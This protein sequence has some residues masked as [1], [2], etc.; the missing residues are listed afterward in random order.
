[1]DGWPNDPNHLAWCQYAEKQ[2]PGLWDLAKNYALLDHFHSSMLGPSFP[3]H[4]FVLAA[5]AGW[6]L[7]NPGNLFPWGCDAFPGT[8]VSVL[9]KG[10]CT[11]QNIFPCLSIP[12]A[13]DILAPGLT[14]KFYGSGISSIVW[15][16]FD[17]IDPI[18]HR[19]TWSNVVPYNPN[20]DKDVQNGTLP[21]VSWLVDQDQA[22]GHPPLSMCAS[23]SWI[24]KHVNEIIRSSSWQNTAVIITW[25]DFG[26][27]VD[28]VA[29]PQ[30]YGCDA[31]HPYGLGFRLPAII[32]SPWVRRGVL[33][34]VTEQA[35]VVRLIEEL[36]SQSHQAGQLHALDPA[37]R[38]DVAGSLLPAFDFTQAPLPAVTA[39]E[40][41]P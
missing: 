7:G 38:D 8:T 2:I 40:T 30:K 36:F 28:H 24:A 13:P 20:F 11:V 19:A 35:S 6:A 18:R 10:S 25:D 41:C 33:H 14:W 4:T 26:G 16:M 39:K 22:S 15:T 37:A 5:Q 23:I 34:D 1:M 3:G 12:S 17:A 29:P 31:T 32:V 27:F 9:Q 21:N